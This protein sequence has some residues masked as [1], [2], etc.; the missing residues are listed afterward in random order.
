MSER[1]V[2][3]VHGA[4]SIVFGWHAG[5]APSDFARELK[6]AV[7]ALT[8]SDCLAGLDLYAELLSTPGSGGVVAL[9]AAGGAQRITPRDV[10]EGR[11]AGRVR[12]AP[13]GAAEEATAPLS[14]EAEQG[15]AGRAAP[16]EPRRAPARRSFARMGGSQ[17][18]F[19]RRRA[20]TAGLPAAAGQALGAPRAAA[21]SR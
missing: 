18:S 15:R 8:G 16:S 5:I 7:R 10:F 4:E 2:E 19:M 9:P 20:A 6:A 11:A 12:I 1:E 13:R 21:R 14:A 17:L 3:L